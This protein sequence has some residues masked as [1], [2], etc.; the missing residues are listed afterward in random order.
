MEYLICAP[1]TSLGTLMH[2][3]FHSQMFELQ[4]SLRYFWPI[5]GYFTGDKGDRN[6]LDKLILKLKQ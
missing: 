1:D 3:S 4:S 5:P 2:I 6:V